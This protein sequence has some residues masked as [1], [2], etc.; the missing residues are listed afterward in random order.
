M[1]LAATSKLST[2]DQLEAVARNL[3]LNPNGTPRPQF[4]E[5]VLNFAE[6]WLGLTSL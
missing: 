4:R 2:P 1:Q 6:Q 3:M 5:L